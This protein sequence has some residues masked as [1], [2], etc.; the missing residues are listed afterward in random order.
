[1]KIL[2]VAVA[3]LLAASP[4][5]AEKNEKVA[6]GLAVGGTAVSSA[7]TL[8]AFVVGGDE[9]TT[10]TPLLVAGVGSFVITP[11]LGHLYSEQWLTI[12]MGIRGVAG[13]MALY[14][15][16]KKQ[17]QAC[18]TRPNDNCPEITSGGLVLI[19]LAAIVYIGGISYDVRDAKDAAKRYNKRHGGGGMA[20]APT[21]MN[22][23]GGL[24]LVGTF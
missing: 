17:D 23:G 2:G 15:A 9:A 8:S 13:A 11:S 21:S 19:S 5:H 24:S 3:S 4:A 16:S 22:H 12:G 6:F 7:L 14:G 18:A 10:N 1:M 20:L